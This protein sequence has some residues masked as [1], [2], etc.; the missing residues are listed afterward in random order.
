M[1]DEI[2][3]VER[4]TT[5]DLKRGIEEMEKEGLPLDAPL[6]VHIKNKVYHVTRIGHFH[7]IPNMTISLKLVE[8]N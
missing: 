7:V 6:E 5:A 4:F 2:V 8:T 1:A 3:E